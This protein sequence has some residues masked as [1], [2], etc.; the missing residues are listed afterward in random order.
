MSDA[1]SLFSTRSQRAIVWWALALA[2]AYGLATV[3]LLHMVP[4][5]AADL[6]AADVAA[7]YRE[8]ATSIR[9]G[10]AICGWS[11]A[12]MLPLLTVVAVQM[13]RLEVGGARIWSALALV[14]GATMSIW[15]AVP[16]IFWG[17]AAFTADRD[18]EITALAHQIGML[19]LVTTDQFYVFL[20]IGVTVLALRPATRRTVHHPFPRWWGYLSLWITGMLELGAL[21]F[22]TD[23]GPLAWSGLLVFWSP[24]TLLA[25]WIGVQAALL[26][27]AL[28]AQEAAALAGTPTEAAA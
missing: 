26:L 12:F 27:R 9:W 16:P 3:L 10:A 14:S 17:A 18:P 1:A 28:A 8:H 5:P 22:V 4:P 6:P 24:L 19:T 21:G 20:W 2:T 11:G 25:V 13:A 15:L 7:F 23:S